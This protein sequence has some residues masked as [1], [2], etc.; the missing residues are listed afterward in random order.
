MDIRFFG[1]LVFGSML[2]GSIKK[3]EAIFGSVRIPFASV[4]FG[5]II[6]KPINTRN[7]N[8]FGS[9]RIVRPKIN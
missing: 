5:Y 9:V 6:E 8:G 4:W 3:T 2:L 1:F 7:L